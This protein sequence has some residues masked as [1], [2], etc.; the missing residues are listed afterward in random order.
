M[1]CRLICAGALAALAVL[2]A[3][4]GLKWYA[5]DPMGELPY[6]PD[7][8]PAGG[9]EGAPLRMVAARGEYEPCSFVLLSDQDMGK[10][11]F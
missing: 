9:R 3:T 1:Q 8:A 7:K 4:A 6:M 5:V 2:P 10:V 11:Q